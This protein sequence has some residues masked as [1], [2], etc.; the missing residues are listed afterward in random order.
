MQFLGD[1]RVSV[2]PQAA[3]EHMMGQQ[4]AEEKPAEEVKEEEKEEKPE[5]EKPANEVPEEARAEA[6][7]KPRRRGGRPVRIM[8]QKKS[9]AVPVAS[10]NRFKQND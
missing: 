6:E 1:N 5:T 10:T 7:N 8:A 2:N 4:P 9:P 3:M